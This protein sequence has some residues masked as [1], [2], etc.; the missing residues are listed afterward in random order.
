MTTITSDISKR[1]LGC[2]YGQAIGDALG[3]TFEFSSREETVKEAKKIKNHHSILPII[4][5]GPFHLV[6]GQV[7]DDTEL[8]MA[9]AHSLMKSNTYD[10]AEAANAYLT[11]YE[12]SPFDIGNTTRAAFSNIR[13]RGETLK[14]DEVYERMS[15]NARDA[16]QNSLSNGILMRISPLAVAGTTWDRNALV[17]SAQVDCCLTNPNSIAQEAV[18]C[19]VAAMQSLIL[20]GDPS[21]SF[22]VAESLATSD[23]I[24]NLLENAKTKAEPINVNIRGTDKEVF[25]ESRS[26]MG[27]LGVAFQVAFYNMLHATSFNEG[28]E[29]AVLLGGD[30]DT[31]GC[32]T[33][34]LLGAR[35]GADTIPDEWKKA[36]VSCKA[37]DRQK[38]YP[39]S[40]LSNIE[41]M[42]ATLLSCKQPPSN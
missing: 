12:S 23:T 29:N 40:D 9:L 13:K 11:W 27:Y 35:F 37:I 16:N 28:V 26:Y 5:G 6:A 17:K 4:G 18:G 2:L 10:P 34:A 32:I 31:N 14:P 41:S 8:A 39:W 3:T 24:K 20:T 38:R 22:K 25:A 7:T 21:E 33:G 36:V 1:A 30:T 42:A 19:Y 15:L